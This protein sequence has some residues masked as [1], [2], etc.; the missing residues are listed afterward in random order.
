MA[1]AIV[2]RVSIKVKPDTVGFKKD[3][4][5]G[6]RKQGDIEVAVDLIADDSGLKRDVERAAKRAEKG[7]KATVEVDADQKSLEKSVDRLAK[8]IETKTIEVMVGADR[9]SLQRSLAQVEAQLQKISTPKLDV[10]LDSA[11]LEAARELIEESLAEIAEEPRMVEF[12]YGNDKASLTKALAQVQAELDKHRQQTIS[13]EADERSLEKIEADIAQ[14]LHQIENPETIKLTVDNDIKGLKEARAKVDKM[15]AERQAFK[16]SVET[17]DESLRKFREHLDEL[18][19]DYDDDTIHL[20]VDVGAAS[21][22]YAATQLAMVSRDRIVHLEPLV[23]SKAYA[24]AESALAALSGGRL[25]TSTLDNVWS[26]LKNLD[27]NIPM[28]G[29]I[30]L[31]VAGIGNS[32]IAATSNLFGL[33]KS[34]AQIAGAGLALPGILGGVAVAIGVTVAAMKDFNQYLPEVAVGLRSLQDSISA[35]FW[36]TA[37][38]PMREFFQVIFP[39]FSAGAKETATTLGLYFGNMASSLKDSLQGRIGP[40]VDNLN[41][42]ILAASTGTDGLA[43]IIA[44]LGSTGSEYLP[45]LAAWFVEITDA[46]SGW[47]SESEKS[48]RLNDIIETGIEQ[49][50]ALGDVL[51]STGRILAGFANAADKAGGSSLRTLADGL[52]RVADKVNDADFQRLLVDAFEAAH[53]VMEDIS[54]VSGPAVSDFFENL[55]GVLTSLEDHVGTALGSLAKGIATALSTDGLNTGI[56][57]MFT[58]LH[59]AITSLQ[60]VWAPLGDA[61]GVLGTTIGTLAES[62]GPLLA[63]MLL[64]MSDAAERLL[65]NIGLIADNLSG[66]L[67]G[68]LEAVGPAIV[69]LADVLLALVEP[70]SS[71]PV[72]VAA[73]AA[74][75]VTLRSAVAAKGLIEGIVSA[76][77]AW[78][79]FSAS[80]PTGATRA[81][82]LASAIGRLAGAAGILAGITVGTNWIIDQLPGATGELD[83]ARLTAMGTALSQIGTGGQ[84]A[85][86][87]LDEFYNRASSNGSLTGLSGT[88]DQLAGHQWWDTVLQA[89]SNLLGWTNSQ[90]LATQA[91]ADTDSQLALMV[92]NGYT[93]A[94]ADAF[95]YLAT[96]SDEAGFSQEKLTANTPLYQAALAGVQAQVDQRII[97][98]DAQIAA[99]AAVTDASAAASAAMRA[100]NDAITA[101][102]GVTPGMISSINEG[103]KAFIDFD[104][105][106][107]DAYTGLGSYMTKL[108]EQIAAQSAW[109]DNMGRLAQKGVSEGV[110][111]ELSKMGPEGGQLVADLTTASDEELAKM[112]QAFKLKSEGAASNLETEFGQLSS[113]VTNTVGPAV[114]AAENALSGL[115]GAMSAAGQDGANGLVAGLRTSIERARNAGAAAGNAYNSGFRGAMDI[116]SPSRVMR[117]SGQFAV[118][119]LVIGLA[120]RAQDVQDEA[121]KI[122][123]I[124][125]EELEQDVEMNLTTASSSARSSAAD[126][127]AGTTGA[128]ANQRT[129]NYYAAPGKSLSSEEDLWAAS[130]RGRM[131]F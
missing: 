12:T 52:E 1:D 98:S 3:A 27:K 33:S 51:K 124:A 15:L 69:T 58:G 4:E 73:L 114:T 7:A 101:T 25:L 95:S 62:F 38:S 68:A 18:I 47:L 125:R 106:M 80:F 121:R 46:F 100:L 72:A 16:F 119:G 84:A 34:L 60:P 45:R 53:N 128:A 96:K 39:E 24:A 19:E 122:A 112:E 21:Y 130:E 5:T 118:D 43:N 2:G 11:S 110:L 70:L 85:K 56:L 129:L 14:A 71:S 37:A 91:L 103:S 93:Q 117:K 127:S 88:L 50:K 87:G 23:D 26:M 17:D 29:T 78:T 57:D 113:K 76:H 116:H 20:N 22:R 82:N 13:V 92:E 83:P 104:G 64:Q 9:A 90:A 6:I 54:R 63:E 123:D 99:E 89:P 75:F 97:Q 94:A 35:N 59:S 67:L 105:A 48:G 36:S 66:V 102:G 40:M 120:D 131:V 77:T 28:I 126:R 32:A 55:V 61:I 30:A 109:A 49:L 108:D 81:T 42:S 79:N 41:A 115:E 107:G 8:K 86:A 31:A 74:A 111:Q 44:I 10:E 65:P